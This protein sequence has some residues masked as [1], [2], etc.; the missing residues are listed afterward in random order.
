MNKVGPVPGTLADGIDMVV[1][2]LLSAESIR[3]SDQ[4]AHHQHMYK[5]YLCRRVEKKAT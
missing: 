1:D 3:F 5:N 4:R 2:Q